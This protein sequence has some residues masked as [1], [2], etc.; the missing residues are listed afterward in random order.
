MG[1]DIARRRLL[2]GGAAF[3]LAAVAG[4]LSVEPIDGEENDDNGVTNIRVA[5]GG[6]PRFDP[7]DVVID[8]G[9][10]VEFEWEQGGFNLEI[11]EQPDGSTWEGEPEIQEAGHVHFHTFEVAG[12]YRFAST[13][14]LL[15]PDDPAEPEEGSITVQED[16]D[17]GDPIG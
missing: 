13:E 9:E 10:T 2:H 14:N 5:P 4:C 16:I 17:P 11:L 3:V 7:P 15:D 6:E 12:L 1:P 8:P